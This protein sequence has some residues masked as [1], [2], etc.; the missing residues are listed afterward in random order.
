MAL[1][2]GATGGHTVK[3]DVLTADPPGVVTETSLAPTVA[4]PLILILAVIWVMLLTVKLLTV[5][6]DP[7]LTDVAPTKPAPVITTFMVVPWLPWLGLVPETAGA[8]Y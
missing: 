5:I 1:Q 8:P 4:D 2:T 6:P 3:A 7:K